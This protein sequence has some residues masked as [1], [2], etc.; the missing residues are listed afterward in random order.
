MDCHDSAMQNLA[1]TK[2]VWIATPSLLGKSTMTAQLYIK[3]QPR[4]DENGATSHKRAILRTI[5]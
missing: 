1:M 5:P 4:N 2:A 3:L